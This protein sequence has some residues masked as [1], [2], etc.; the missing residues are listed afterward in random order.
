MIV[1]HIDFGDQCRTHCW[2]LRLTGNISLKAQF[3]KLTKAKQQGI[4]YKVQEALFVN[5]VRSERVRVSTSESRPPFEII[6]VAFLQ[7]IIEDENWENQCH[8][9]VIS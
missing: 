8:A 5:Q 9:F 2:L 4:R 7:P 6:V 3:S 1:N